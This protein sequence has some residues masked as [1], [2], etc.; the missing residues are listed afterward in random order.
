ML[1]IGVVADVDGFADRVVER[2]TRHGLEAS[3]LTV[4]PFGARPFV[5]GVRSAATSVVDA[6]AWIEADGTDRWEGAIDD[7]CRDR[8]VPFDANLRSGRR[9]PRRRHPEIV[10]PDAEWPVTAQR[11]IGRLQWAIGEQAIRI[12]HIGSTAV[13]G[14]PAKDLIDIQVAVADL[15]GAGCVAVAA[16]S[17]G[18]VHVNGSWFG[19]DRTGAAHREEVC[20]DADPGR[21][22]N[23]NIRPVSAPV[24]RDT[25]LLRDWL[26]QSPSARAEYGALKR[27]LA[28]GSAS[29]VDDYGEKKMPWIRAALPVA[30]EWARG[31][32][33]T[34]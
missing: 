14:L 34:P 2:F 3:R 24:W 32:G 22:V 20:V 8:L 5:V 23:V 9:A 13:P 26:R 19:E 6:D 25:L 18:F 21:P 17:A 29:D 33:W 12:D 10:E 16:R 28:L 1:T 4:E 11:L 30:E 7:L 27:E 15:A 31:T